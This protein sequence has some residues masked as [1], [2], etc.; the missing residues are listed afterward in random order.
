MPTSCAPSL[1]LIQ[2]GQLQALDPA[3]TGQLGRV[4]A[5]VFL[6]RLVVAVGDHQHDLLPAEVSDQESEQVA[7]GA[8][9]PVQILDHQHQRSLLA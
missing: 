6:A 1:G 5:E 9:G 3:A 2:S 7:G 4:G 8:V